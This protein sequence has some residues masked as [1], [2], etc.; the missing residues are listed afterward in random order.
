MP[1]PAPASASLAEV[2]RDC[3]L[4]V[5]EVAQ[6][7][8]RCWVY[9]MG[10]GGLTL[11]TW[12]HGK[13]ARSHFA[14]VSV[15]RP[16]VADASWNQDPDDTHAWDALGEVTLQDGCWTNARVRVCAR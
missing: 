13:P 12:T 6:V 15:T 14:V 1:A 8:G 3:L 5:D 7:E 16:G 9:P 11:N 2:Q 10:D 4:V